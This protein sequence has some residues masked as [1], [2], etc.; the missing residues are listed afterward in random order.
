MAEQA[1]CKRLDCVGKMRGGRLAEAGNA[2]VGR[3]LNDRL[4][5]AGVKPGGSEKGQFKRDVHGRNLNIGNTHAR[6]PAPGQ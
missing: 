6:P 1:R 5:R 3:Y 4:G 2:L